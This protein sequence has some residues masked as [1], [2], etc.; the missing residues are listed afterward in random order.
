[1]AFVYR[2][3][4]QEERDYIA[5]FKIRAVL[6]GVLASIP[7]EAAVDDERN[8]Y[9]YQFD[10]QGWRNGED[11]APPG[12]CSLIWG[13]AGISGNDILHMGEK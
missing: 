5:S 8:I 3:L 11:D 9:Y 12:W 13:G 7:K 4:T 10:G 1:M 6:G 2:E